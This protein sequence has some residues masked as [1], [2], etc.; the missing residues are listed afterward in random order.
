MILFLS[1]RDYSRMGYLLS[2][3]L[4][5]VGVESISLVSKLS[6]EHSNDNQSLLYSSQ[7][8]LS[9]FVKRASVIIWMHSVHTPVN[10]Y[11]QKGTKLVVFHGGSRYRVGYKKKNRFFNPLVDMSIIQTGELLELGAKNKRWLLPPIDVDSIKPKFGVHNPIIIGHYPSNKIDPEH[12]IKGTLSIN[13]VIR[14]LKRTTKLDFKYKYEDAYKVFPRVSWKKNLKRMGKCD[15]YIESLNIDSTSDNQHDWSL[16]AL[17]AAA[18]GKIV[19][20]NFRY[21]DKYLKEYGNCELQIVSR[22]KELRKVLIRLLKSSPEELET[23]QR[24]T[25]AW[26]EKYHNFEAVGNRLK[27]FINDI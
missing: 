1:V 10:D 18:L 11:I 12:D 27:T 24:R 17:E 14:D 15:I 13:K 20:T 7:E 2:K 23:L 6:L 16:T 26:V 19:I 3:S 25:R 9:K 22:K 8:E 4:N 5:K 21:K